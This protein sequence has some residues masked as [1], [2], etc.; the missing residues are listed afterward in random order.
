MKKVSKEKLEWLIYGKALKMV[1]NWEYHTEGTYGLCKLLRKAKDVI[2]KYKG[3]RDILPYVPNFNIEAAINSGFLTYDN[4]GVEFKNTENFMI[5][6]SYSHCYWWGPGIWEKKGRLGFLISLYLKVCHNLNKPILTNTEAYN[7]L[8]EVIKRHKKSHKGICIHI[9]SI[10]CDLEEKE[11]KT[12]KDI[13]LLSKLD[14]ILYNGVETAKGLSYPI[15][16]SLLGGNVNS[17]YWWSQDLGR[18]LYLRILLMYYKI[19]MLVKA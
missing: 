15:L 5:I 18:V 7:L 9:A 10:A 8:T 4:C 12:F 2:T 19:K 1:S 16:V 17:T 3:Y 14:S 11:N 6:K 13:I